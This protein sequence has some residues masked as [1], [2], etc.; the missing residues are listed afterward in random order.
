M[1]FTFKRAMTVE[2]LCKGSF[3]NGEPFEF[4][5]EFH[6]KTA[7]ELQELQDKYG[8]PDESENL[9][10]E[11]GNI[12]KADAVFIRW[13]NK[14]DDPARWVG[15]PDETG[16]IIPLDFSEKGR[17]DMLKESGVAFGIWYSYIMARFD[18]KAILGNSQPSPGASAKAKAR[19]LKAIPPA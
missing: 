14:E 2:I 5:G 1:G 15:D 6:D 10:T 7:E 19:G 18:A 9:I 12:P 4:W 3:L 11:Y 8:N 16:T 17:Q 13:I